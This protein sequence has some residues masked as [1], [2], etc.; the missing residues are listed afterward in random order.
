MSLFYS[1]LQLC[2]NFIC[3]TSLLKWGDS[4]LSTLPQMTYFKSDIWLSLFKYPTSP[5]RF[6]LGSKVLVRL[7]QP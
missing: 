3:F 6:S 2:N 1:A 7:G 5:P 4:A